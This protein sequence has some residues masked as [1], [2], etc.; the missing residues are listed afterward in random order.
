LRPARR[1]LVVGA[2]TLAATL[3]L[4]AAA[5]AAPYY[6]LTNVHSGKVLMPQN[7]SKAWGTTIVQQN[8]QNAG[9]QTWFVETVGT[10][11]GGSPIVRFKN[12]HSKLCI[13]PSDWSG[14]SG[15][16]LLQASCSNNSEAKWYR[17]NWDG[18]LYFNSLKT[19]KFMD[20]AGSSVNAGATAVQFDYD[21]TVS[22]RWRLVYAGNV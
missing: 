20:I 9:A 7:H 11:P 19:S 2:L 16:R 4:A 22:Q 13:H 1:L 6:Y 12:R 8:L 5:S 3:G 17:Y 15:T 21:G 14:L 10:G 18:A